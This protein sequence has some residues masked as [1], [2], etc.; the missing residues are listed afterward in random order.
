MIQAKTATAPFRMSSTPGHYLLYLWIHESHTRKELF[1]NCVIKLSSKLEEDFFSLMV[2]NAAQRCWDEFKDA[3]DHA[4]DE[5]AEESVY[6]YITQ[7]ENL[8]N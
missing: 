6:S 4:T 3:Y 2:D 5:S 7:S 8:I 1:E